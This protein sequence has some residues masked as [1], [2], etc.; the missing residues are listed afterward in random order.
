[1]SVLK[2]SFNYII[3]IHNKADLIKDVILGV[4]NSAGPEST[5]Y[6]VL[7]GC[8]DLSEAVIDDLIK[9]YPEHRIIK[10]YAEDVHELKSIN[11]GLNNSNQ[12]G[13]GYNIILQ[14]DVVLQDEKL[15]ERCIEL[16]DSFKKLGVVSFRHGANISRQLLEDF[17]NP[18]PLIDY[19]QSECG[20]YPKPSATLKIGFFVFKEI[21]IKSPI[22]IPFQVIRELGVPDEAYAPWNDIAYTYRVSATGYKNGV[23]AIKFRSDV[24]WGTT[25]NKKQ[26]LDVEDVQLKNGLLFRFQY[27]ELPPLDEKY[28]N[29]RE[30]FF[31]D[32]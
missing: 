28:S 6:P 1:M 18:E 5:I 7:D 21:V 14:D 4:I 3:T 16:Y 29:Y 22:C 17:T 20:H 19:I 25:R 27:R 9:L 31:F 10:L 24:S 26:E 30:Y 15:E 12:T 13:R 2:I 8:T 23:F 32:V 11:I